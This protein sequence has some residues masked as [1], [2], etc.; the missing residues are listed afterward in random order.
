MSKQFGAAQELKVKL[1]DSI[2]L[3]KNPLEIIL[4]IAELLGEM[5]GEDSYKQNIYDQLVSVYGLALRDKFIL[6]Q[7]LQEV[8]ER[9]KKI[10]SAYENPEFTDEEHKRIG[11]A[12]ERHKAEI[13]RLKKLGEED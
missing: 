6:S 9:L 11:Y 7:E 13:E 5:S 2:N 8:S 1:N 3:A 12:I 10:E 4:E